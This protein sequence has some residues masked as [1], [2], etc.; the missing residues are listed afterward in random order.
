MRQVQ[1][2]EGRLAKLVACGAEHSVAVLTTG[3]VLTWGANNSGQAGLGKQRAHK[4]ILKPSMVDIWGE[5]EQGRVFALAAGAHH[6]VVACELSNGE[7]FMKTWGA[8]IDGQTGCDAGTHVP[9]WTPSLIS[10]LERIHL[11]MPNMEVWNVDRHAEGC[12]AF[13]AQTVAVLLSLSL[14]PTVLGEEAV[15]ALATF[16][17]FAPA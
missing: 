15:N 3:E 12:W 7:Q 14:L 17:G 2:L 11:A 4:P 9:T 16:Y 5:R 1:L 10:G 8:N 13:K 6:T